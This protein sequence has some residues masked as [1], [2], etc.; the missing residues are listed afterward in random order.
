MGRRPIHESG[1]RIVVSYPDQKLQ[2][3]SQKMAKSIV[4]PAIIGF[5]TIWTG[6]SW[7]RAW[8]RCLLLRMCRP[9]SHIM[10]ETPYQQ[11][12]KEW[13]SRKS[14]R[15][16]LFPNRNYRRPFRISCWPPRLCSFRKQGRHTRTRPPNNQ[17]PQ[18]MDRRQ[19][20]ISSPPQINSH[21]P[22]RLQ[23]STIH[24]WPSIGN[25]QQTRWRI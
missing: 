4:L 11:A 8:T 7:R 23:R 14:T 5:L 22:R 18:S 1:L 20:Q 19:P 6:K 13:S 2:G 9:D 10:V 12:T 25:I 3:G 15:T 24:M 16:R 17:S 21:T